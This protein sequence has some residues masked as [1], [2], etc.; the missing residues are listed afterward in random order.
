MKAEAAEFMPL[1]MDKSFAAALPAARY[2]AAPQGDN[3]LGGA[4]S[5]TAGKRIGLYGG[6]FNPPHKGHLLVAE[7]ALKKLKLDCVWWLVSPGNPLKDISGLAPL[8]ERIK[9]AEELIGAAAQMRITAFEQS[10]GVCGTAAMLRFITAANPRTH[11]VWIMGA[12]NLANFHLWQDWRGIMETVPVAVVDR[13]HFADAAGS[14]A[15]REFAAARLDERRAA[16]LAAA[17]APA[18]LLLHG[19]RSYLSSTLLRER[20]KG[21]QPAA[22]HAGKK[23]T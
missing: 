3:G 14:A 9:A 5:G 18:W 23:T 11:F 7:T 6:S 12:D 8:R 19:R 1:S 22:C 16:D 20:E 10:L 15:A 17:P 2:L 4:K 13:P 21:G